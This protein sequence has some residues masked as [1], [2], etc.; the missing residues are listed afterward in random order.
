MIFLFFLFSNCCIVYAWSERMT[1]SNHKIYNKKIKIDKPKGLTTAD[2]NISSKRAQAG[3]QLP[4]E[5]S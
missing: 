4:T 3:R 5:S 1:F 2:S